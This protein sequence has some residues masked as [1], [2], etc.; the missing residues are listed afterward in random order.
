V[1]CDQC[2]GRLLFGRHRNRTGTPYDYFSC[3]NR[4]VRRRRIRCD[5]SAHYPVPKV[6]DHVEQLYRTLELSED[7][8]QQIRSELRQGLS[9]RAALIGKEAET[10]ERMLKKIEAKQEKLVQLFYDDLVTAD[11]FERQQAK[12]K[13]ETKAA[14]RL[15]RVAITET[16]NIEEALE[17]ALRRLDRI[18]AS[19]LEA[20]PLE[21]RVMNRA[22]FERIEV[23]ED[24]TITGTTLTPTYKALSA[25]QPRLGRPSR[26]QACAQ[27]PADRRSVFVRPSSGTAD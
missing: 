10:H 25:W 24:S 13:A 12:L 14:S 8:K 16:Q 2:K 1:L 5:S 26:N 27:E 17:E 18:H 4:A 20:T 3:T 21:R 22:I 15:R 19:Y 9:D 11:V 6:E 7:V 23:G